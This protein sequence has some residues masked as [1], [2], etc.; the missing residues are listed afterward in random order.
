MILE[1]ILKAFVFNSSLDSEVKPSLVI[2]L[3]VLFFCVMYAS[4]LCMYIGNVFLYR[5]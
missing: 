3:D 2:K 4:V 1:E 5:S